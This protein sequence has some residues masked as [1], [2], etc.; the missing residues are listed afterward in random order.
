V[1]WRGF[2]HIKGGFGRRV[3]TSVGKGL[4]FGTNNKKRAA[5]A[6]LRPFYVPIFQEKV[7]FF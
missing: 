3:V 5:K 7:K 4:I 2:T 1:E 6:N